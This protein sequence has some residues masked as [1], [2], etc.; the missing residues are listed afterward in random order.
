[1]FSDGVIDEQAAFRYAR[2]LEDE[3]GVSGGI[4]RH[5]CLHDLE[6]AGFG[7]DSGKLLELV[8]LYHSRWER[9][10]NTRVD[11]RKFQGHRAPFGN[12]IGHY[13]LSYNSY[14]L[15]PFSTL[16]LGSREPQRAR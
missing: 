9:D 7:D 16:F 14:F 1:V 15:S 8:E 5:K 3:G 4:L 6:I 12:T 13:P 10:P 11:E 2:G